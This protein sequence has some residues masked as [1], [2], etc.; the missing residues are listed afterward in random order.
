MSLL[1]VNL[2]SQNG[3]ARKK[4]ERVRKRYQHHTTFEIRGAEDWLRLEGWLITRFSSQQNQVI[5]A[6]GDGT[7]HSV[8]QLIMKHRLPA[9]L[10]MI[11]LG[12]SN[13]YHKPHCRKYQEWEGGVPVRLHF[14]AAKPHDLMQFL[15]EDGQSR[16]ERWSGL[17]G[18]MGITA[19]GNEIFNRAD[20][21]A[22]RLKPYSVNAAIA[23]AALQAFMKSER[24]RI[25]LQ[26]DSE[27]PISKDILNLGIFKRAH[28]SGS[29]HYDRAPEV[30]DGK[31]GIALL[32]DCSKLSQ[33][34]V[35]NN[36]ASG[37]FSHM[38]YCNLKMAKQVQI[39]ANQPLTLEIDGE[40][41]S[42][43]QAHIRVAQRAL[44]MCP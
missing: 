30:D 29:F 28:F 23:H 24:F 6:G 4:W 18:S 12:S 31:I 1:I 40:T 14:D 33:F 21:I 7:V 2:C 36:L 39:Q 22:S 37:K 16:I 13:D 42:G 43:T 19:N 9:R 35:L 10:G 27:S 20:S 26:I 5:A 15:V 32:E 8:I 34:R 41:L 25:S 44:S 11:G 38:K 17:N 3:K